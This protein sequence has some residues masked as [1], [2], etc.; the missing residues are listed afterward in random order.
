MLM[1]RQGVSDGRS[2]VHDSSGECRTTHR[3]SFVE[4]RSGG[5]LSSPGAESKTAF[6]GLALSADSYREV[7]I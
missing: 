5:V 2:H 6:R 1:S 4:C 7:A 3:I